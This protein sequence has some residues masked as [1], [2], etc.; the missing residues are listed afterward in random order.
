M[1]RH[2]ARRRALIRAVLTFGLFTATTLGAAPS[3]DDPFSPLSAGLIPLAKSDEQQRFEPGSEVTDFELVDLDGELQRFSSLRGS[4]VIVN[5][6]ATWC[7][8]CRAEMPLLQAFF[9]EHRGDGLV[10]L[11][12]DAGESVEVVEPFLMETEIT[13]PVWLDPPG[14]DPPGSVT[15]ALFRRFGGFGLPMTFFVDAAG[16]LVGTHLGE[17]DRDTLERK[18]K[19]ILG[20]GSE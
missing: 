2:P 18:S 8:P 12:I 20:S 10:I 1:P 4:P 5:F 17:I 13:Y 14:T 3:F 9:E 7:P 11:G 6:W 16:V 15:L 19:I